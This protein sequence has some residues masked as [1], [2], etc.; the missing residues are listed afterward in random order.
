MYD[1]SS[2]PNFKFLPFQSEQIHYS[3]V[4]RSMHYIGITKQILI[5]QDIVRIFYIIEL[6]SVYNGRTLIPKRIIIEYRKLGV[7]F[8]HVQDGAVDA[9][10]V[11]SI[12]HNEETDMSRS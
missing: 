4:G 12:F 11:R 1:C 9:A 8:M 7:Y 3:S 5:F 10:V 6:P 2:L